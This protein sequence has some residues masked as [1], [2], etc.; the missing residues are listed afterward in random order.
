MIH[1]NAQ[2]PLHLAECMIRCLGRVANGLGILGGLG[3]FAR[4]PLTS[5]VYH[6]DAGTPVDE[7]L[8]YLGAQGAGLLSKRLRM[9]HFRYPPTR[10]SG[11]FQHHESRR[12]CKR[13]LLRD[14]MERSLRKVAAGR[15]TF[16]TCV[17]E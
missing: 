16:M 11:R 8:L 1:H 6:A 3:K 14:P 10:V 7:L 13:S 4:T 12:V 17:H 15:R 2:I 5:K 9:V